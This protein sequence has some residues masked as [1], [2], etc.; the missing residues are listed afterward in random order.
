MLE[1]QA[2]GIRKTSKEKGP[3]AG[4]SKR[5]T[6]SRRRILA[7]ARKLFVERGYHETRPQDISREAGVG[8]GT[9]YLHFTDKLDCF[10]AFADEAAN[11]LEVILQRHLDP[12]LTMEE[13]IRETLLAINEYS[14]ANPGVLQASMTDLDVISASERRF[15]P[16]V[17]RWGEHWAEMIKGWQKTGEA[18]ADLDPE[19]AGRAA[20]GILRQV[21]AYGVEREETPDTMLEQLASLLVKLL[22]K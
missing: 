15:E 3:E 10:L 18:S 19:F 22:R 5:R 17:I 7:A 2:K 12:D 1:T 16:P 9:F 4:T 14:E 8:H 6:D 20:L 21:S 13:A 11:E